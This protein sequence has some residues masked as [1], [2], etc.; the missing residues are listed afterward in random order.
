[1]EGWKGGG[2]WEGFT[3]AV[4]WCALA[5]KQAR[6]P[7]WQGGELDR[8]KPRPR[9]RHLAAPRPHQHATT[10]TTT[11]TASKLATLTARGLTL[12]SFLP[13][14]MSSSVMGSR[15]CWGMLKRSRSLGR[16]PS[17]LMSVGVRVAATAA[18]FVWVGVASNGLPHTVPRK[19]QTHEHA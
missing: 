16:T 10:I 9:L 4:R 6:A 3:A 1:V 15:H 11:P 8:C 5:S 17:H 2:G 13:V 19:P 18:Y 12:T 14:F 7:A